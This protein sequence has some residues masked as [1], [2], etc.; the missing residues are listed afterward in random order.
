M[1]NLLLQLLIH[2]L[3]YKDIKLYKAKQ[4]HQRSI[5]FINIDSTW[6]FDINANSSTE[7]ECARR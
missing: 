7:Q 5:I 6:E 2:T 3:Y 1:I 4:L